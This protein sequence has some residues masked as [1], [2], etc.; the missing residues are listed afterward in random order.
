MELG[1]P[2]LSIRKWRAGL[3]VV[4]LFIPICRT[5]AVTLAAEAVARVESSAVLSIPL[6]QGIK[7]VSGWTLP[8]L[9]YLATIFRGEGTFQVQHCVLQCVGESEVNL[10]IE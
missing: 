9:R 6:N 3:V 2:D 1:V 8:V 4:T 5:A 7:P 10:K